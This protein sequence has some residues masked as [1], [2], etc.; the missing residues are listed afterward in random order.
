MTE[1]MAEVH[2]NP[3]LRQTCPVGSGLL[4]LQLPQPRYHRTSE[5]YH[6]PHDVLEEAARHPTPTMVLEAVARP[7]PRIP[8]VR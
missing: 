7:I 3:I 8:P 5:W 1:S 2:L 4:E 6:G